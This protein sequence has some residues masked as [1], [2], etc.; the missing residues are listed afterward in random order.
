MKHPAVALAAAIGVP[1]PTRTEVVKA[2]V[3]LKD[4]YEAT[5]DLAADIQAFVKHRMAAHA[6]PRQV[7]FV[8]SL[9]MTPTGKIRRKDLR[10][11]R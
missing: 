10:E 2:F 6:Y 4:G 8:E 7:A 11:I 5:P 9:P 3:V 1:D